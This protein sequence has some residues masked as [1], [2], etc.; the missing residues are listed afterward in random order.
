M[1]SLISVAT[2]L[3]ME[4]ILCGVWVHVSL[5]LFPAEVTTSI[6]ASMMAWTAVSSG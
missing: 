4:A 3:K 1:V 5:A 6:P 2:T